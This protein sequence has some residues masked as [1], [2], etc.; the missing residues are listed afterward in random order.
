MGNAI[1]CSANRRVP[2]RGITNEMGLQRICAFARIV[3]HEQ[4]LKDSF[5]VNARLQQEVVILDETHSAA[6]TWMIGPLRPPSACRGAMASCRLAGQSKAASMNSIHSCHFS[7]R[8]CSVLCS[9]STVSFTN[10][11]IAAIPPDTGTLISSMLMSILS[12]S[13]GARL[14]W[15]PS[16]QIAATAPSLCR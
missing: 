14:T 16:Y 5:G 12:C 4:L 15:K 2:A 1:D 8:R 13:T 6:R 10:S 3:D 11:T 9:A 7:I